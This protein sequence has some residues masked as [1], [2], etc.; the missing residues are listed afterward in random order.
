MKTN[1]I[2]TVIIFFTMVTIAFAQSSRPKPTAT[3]RPKPS[4]VAIR[5]ADFTTIA[6]NAVDACKSDSALPPL[7]SAEFDFKVQ[8]SVSGNVGID[9]W[10]ISVGASRTADNL[11]DTTFTYDDP[12]SS[13]STSNEMFAFDTLKTLQTNL[14]SLIKGAAAAAK[15]VPNVDAALFHKLTVTVQFQVKNEASAGA[16]IPI[17]GLVFG[18]KLTG[19]QSETHSIKLVFTKPAKAAPSPAPSVSP[20]A[21][22]SATATP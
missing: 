18:P 6:K 9:V 16:K 8:T 22:P 2:L 5:L 21:L 4:P 7:S 20:N 10:I 19:S 15:S 17:W 1:P 3:A 13:K 14:I 11:S 12:N